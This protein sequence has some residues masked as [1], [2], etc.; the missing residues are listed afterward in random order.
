[1]L[2]LSDINQANVI[3][4]INSTT[5]YQ[6]DLPDIDNPNEQMV[7]QIYPTELQ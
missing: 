4:A 2:S 1:M 5:G 6:D 7:V 3:G